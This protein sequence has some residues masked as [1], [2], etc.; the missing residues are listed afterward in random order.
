MGEDD[1]KKGGLDHE[2]KHGSWEGSQ[3]RSSYANQRKVI[4]IRRFTRSV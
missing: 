1:A 2:A 3:H 4:A